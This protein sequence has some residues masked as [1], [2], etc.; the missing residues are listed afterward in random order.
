MV[1][2][3]CLKRPLS[4]RNLFANTMRSALARYFLDTTRKVKELVEAELSLVGE[5]G[6]GEFDGDD[7]DNEDDK[8]DV[9]CIESLLLFKL[10]S[11]GKYGFDCDE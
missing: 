9:D 4:S 1:L 3:V 7:V 6:G 2:S 5:N 8:A 10:I 11:R